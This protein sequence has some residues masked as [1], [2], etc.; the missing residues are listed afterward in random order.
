[1][2]RSLALLGA[3]LAVVVMPAQLS[4][5]KALLRPA[6]EAVVLITEQEAA[7]PSEGRTPVM[8]AGNNVTDQRG[9]TRNPKIELV[10]PSA[11]SSS[12]LIHFEIRFSAVHGSRIDPAQVRISYLKQPAIDLTPRVAAF[13]RSDGIDVPSA[14]VARGTHKLQI[15]IVDGEGRKSSKQVTLEIAD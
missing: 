9:I 4:A 6:E 14:Q 15:D 7:L 1:M 13:I 3:A 8:L 2:I 5:Q 11:A 12:P 10:S